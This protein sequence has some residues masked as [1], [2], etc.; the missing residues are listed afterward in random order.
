[1][2]GGGLLQ[3]HDRDTQRN[4]F[5]CSSQYRDDKWNDVYKS[6]LDASKASKR[7]RLKL[8]QD[9]DSMKTVR[10]EEDGENLLKLVFECGS[11]TNVQSFEAIRVN[12]AL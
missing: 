8:I 9:G 4:A 3:K 6:P 1:M 10:I 7:G 2:L 5:K 11:L 12:A